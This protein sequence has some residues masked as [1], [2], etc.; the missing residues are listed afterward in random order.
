MG[1]IICV[2]MKNEIIEW[3][4]SKT[5]RRYIHPPKA[6]RIITLWAEGKLML[7]EVEVNPG[8][9][10]KPYEELLCHGIWF[11]HGDN[12]SADFKTVENFITEDGVPVHAIENDYG[13]IRANIET[14][15]DIG[16]TPTCYIKVTLKNNTENKVTEKFGFLLRTGAEKKLIFGSPDG[17]YP[18]NPDIEVWKKSES[19]WNKVNDSLFTDGERF[20][21]VNGASFEWDNSSGSATMNL[22][23]AQN[24][25]K[26]FYLSIGKGEYSAFDY[27]NIKINTAAWWR[28]ELEKINRLPAH[29]LADAQKVKIIRHLTTQILQNFCY[30]VGESFLLCRQGGLQR[31]IWPFEALFAMEAICRIGDFGEYVEEVISCYFDV[32]QT[33]EGEIVPLGLHWAMVTGNVLYSFAA[34]CRTKNGK[35]FYNKYRDKAMRA[36]EWIRKTRASTADRDDCFP[37]LFPPLQSCDCEYVFQAFLNTDFRVAYDLKRFV[38]IVAE[39]KDVRADEVRREYEDYIKVLDYHFDYLRK[40]SEGKDEMRHSAFVP[41]F[42]GDEALFAFQPAVRNIPEVLSLTNEEIEKLINYGKKRGFMAVRGLYSKMKDNRKPSEYNLVDDDGETRVW[43]TS[44]T[45]YHWFYT[46]MRMGDRARAKE[47][48]DATI[49]YSMTDELYMIER[50]HPRNPYF[51]PWSPNTSASGRLIQ[52]MLDFEE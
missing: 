45:E 27:E 14:V 24:E 8:P 30:P 40:E 23:L 10:A 22:S 7:G 36:F 25:E 49:K 44:V 6:E 39:F 4:R 33:K 46:F 16:R 34:Y 12:E 9:T 43:Y 5:T 37:G 20:V 28:R 42:K 38:D 35:D 18:H 52:M 47:T 32:L 19:T 15:C 11:V 17:Y 51:A 31:F 48:L 41:S 21:G 2:G 3:Q 13:K 50:Y 1:L 29:I 26:V